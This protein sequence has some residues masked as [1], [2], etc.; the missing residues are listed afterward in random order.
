[1]GIQKKKKSGLASVAKKILK[2][3]DGVGSQTGKKF[4]RRGK[5]G[6]KQR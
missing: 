3:P 6:R 2:Q 1:L 4:M 5:K